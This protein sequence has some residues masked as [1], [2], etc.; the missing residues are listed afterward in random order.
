MISEI[1]KIKDMHYLYNSVLNQEIRRGLEQVKKLE[2]TRNYLIGNIEI[3]KP[4][5]VQC[6]KVDFEGLKT[7]TQPIPEY[8]FLGASSLED[9][10]NKSYSIASLL[11]QTNS[12]INKEKKEIEKNQSKIIDLKTYR[13]II[14]LFN[15]KISRE[16]LKGYTF[17]MGN[18]LSN[19]RIRKRI[20][21]EKS[22]KRI[23][24]EKSNIFKKELILEG[25]LPFKVIEYD[26]MKRPITNNGGIKW[27]IYY[28]GDD[29][30]WYWEKQNC[31]V[32]NERI[33]RFR[34][35]VNS[36]TMG[37]KYELGNGNKL[38]KLQR[39][40]SEYLKYFNI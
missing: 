15:K 33:Y 18:Q 31:K 21:T 29:Y 2:A 4:Y 10:A 5:L 11:I 8:Y 39:E 32:L 25:K 6:T 27:H 19:I 14:E 1:I 9:F 34:P 3:C 28:T 35:T 13:I 37:G 24:W 40:N 38:K 7:L 20:F 30:L 26:E 23:D 12:L 17:R 36:N 22:R 16:I